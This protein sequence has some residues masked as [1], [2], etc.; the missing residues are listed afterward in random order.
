MIAPAQNSKIGNKP[1]KQTA[2]YINKNGRTVH[3]WTSKLKFAFEIVDGES[4]KRKDK[5]VVFIPASPRQLIVS[6]WRPDQP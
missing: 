5:I 2:Q 4:S 6:G 3:D 1:E